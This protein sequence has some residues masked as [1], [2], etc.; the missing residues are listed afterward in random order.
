MECVIK[1]EEEKRERVRESVCVGN[2]VELI[3]ERE[4]IS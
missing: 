2:G 3:H 1:V 4:D